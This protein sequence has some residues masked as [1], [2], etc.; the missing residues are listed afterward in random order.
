MAFGWR[1]CV[2]AGFHRNERRR[3]GLDL[4]GVPPDGDT[5]AGLPDI[6]QPTLKHILVGSYFERQLTT[7]T[8]NTTMETIASGAAVGAVS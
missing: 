3:L 4:D 8:R 7:K 5:W 2:I 6:V 1:Y